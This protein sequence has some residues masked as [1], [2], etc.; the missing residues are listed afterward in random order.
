MVALNRTEILILG[1]HSYCRGVNNFLRLS[2]GNILD[3]ANNKLTKVI[4]DFD[5][6]DHSKFIFIAQSNAFAQVRPGSVVGLAE[7][8]NCDLFM[9]G[10]EK[11]QSKV[12]IIEQ[13]RA[14]L[15]IYE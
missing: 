15:P 9:I 8:Q 14:D 11:G 10:Y 13:I 7:D 4:A 3:T 6:D 12:R 5:P 2:E 1:G